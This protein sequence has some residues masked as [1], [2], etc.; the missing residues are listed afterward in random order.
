MGVDLY[1]LNFL[2][3]THAIHKRCL[4]RTLTSGRQGFHITTVEGRHWA[5]SILRTHDP[6]ASLDEMQP[7]GAIWAD[8]LLRYLAALA[9]PRWMLRPLRARKSSMISTFLSGKAFMVRLIQSLTA[10]R[11]S[12][13]SI[14]LNV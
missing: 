10:V 2:V 8:G 6:R 9:S 11:S 5:E 7:L 1:V 3:A 14:F 4:G 13:S 12:I